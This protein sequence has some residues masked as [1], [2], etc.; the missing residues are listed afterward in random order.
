M[1]LLS[2]D[3]SLYTLI[4]RIKPSA[5]IIPGGFIHA[6]WHISPVSGLTGESWRISYPSNKTATINWLAREQSV[7]KTQLGVD[8]RRERKLLRHVAGHHL[9]PTVIAA[10][11]HWLVVNWLGGDV[12]TNAQFIELSNNGQ[13]AEL[14]T[15]LHH[16]PAS[17]YRLDLRAQLIRYARQIDSKRLSPHWLRLHQHFLRRPLPQ[18][19][20]LAP[21]HMDIHPGNLLTTPSGLKL[22]DWEYAADGDVALDI[23]ALFRGNSWSAPQ[24]QAFLQHYCANEQG[25]HDIERLSRQIQRWEPWVDYLMLM[26]FEVRWQQTGN[27]EFLQWVAPLRRRF[28]LSF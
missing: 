12:V 15:R 21:L 19:L 24:Q 6:N 17:G 14:L 10:D 13:L 1:V 3:P 20:K 11:Q 9:A 2:A 16:L 8:R 22:I 26:W 4:E 27:T 18:T 23:A 25:Y 28:N 7:Q 5:D